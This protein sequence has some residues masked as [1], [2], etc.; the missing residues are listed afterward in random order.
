[1]L[2]GGMTEN[3]LVVRILAKDSPRLFWRFYESR[4]MVFDANMV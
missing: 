4:K 1:M 3:N 2:R